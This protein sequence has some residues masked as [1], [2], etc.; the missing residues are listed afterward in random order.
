MDHRLRSLES[1]QACAEFGANPG[2]LRMFTYAPANLPPGAPLVVVLH[3]C[4]QSAA[5]YC[6]GAGW[7]DL[8]DRL[9]FAV[10]AP[11][12]TS[13]NNFNVC[14]SWFQAADAA[15]GEGEAASIAQMI[16]QAIIDHDLDRGR[17]FITGLS[18]GGAMA[19]VMLAAYPEL[20]AGGAIVAG[21]PYGAARNLQD[22]VGAMHKAP[23]L[24]PEDWG[25]KVRVASDHAGPW[26]RISIWH[27]DADRTVAAS[28]AEAIVA[29]WTN[30]ERI[31]SAPAFEDVVDGYPR[32]VWCGADGV[33]VIESYTLAGLGHGTPI[34]AGDG[35]DRGGEAGP[36]L[37]EAGIFSSLH[38]AAFWGLA[39]APALKRASPRAAKTEA[40][41]KP[42]LLG[43]AAALAGRRP[44]P[45]QKVI[46]DALKVAGVLKRR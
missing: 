24:T 25:D 19:S 5:A 31:G 33:R 23:A 35:P 1:L 43:E 34:A 36:F 10:L 32:R 40:A 28:N 37:L 27:G 30:V 42:R 3:G 45:L 29:Q 2:A 17:V 16:E 39:K 38:I 6:R 22:A 9:G 13:S 20:F 14:F 26:P 41:P 7:I 18:A 12:Q 15:R 4:G 8:A 11:Q 46:E 44:A 21:L